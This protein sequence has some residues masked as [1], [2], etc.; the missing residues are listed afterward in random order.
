M[1]NFQKF[2]QIFYKKNANAKQITNFHN[3]WEDWG[4]LLVYINTNSK[5]KISL[6]HQVPRY[7]IRKLEF[8]YQ[9]YVSIENKITFSSDKLYFQT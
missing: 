3:F 9:F 5:G 1:I 8:S 4:C 2:C 7:K 6:K